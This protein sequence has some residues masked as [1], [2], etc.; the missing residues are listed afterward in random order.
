LTGNN[1]GIRTVLSIPLSNRE[2]RISLSESYSFL[3]LPVFIH[4]IHKTNKTAKRTEKPDGKPVLCQRTF[5]SDFLA[6]FYPVKLR[7]LT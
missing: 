7:S 3:I 5:S 6:V 2:L 1:P 4:H